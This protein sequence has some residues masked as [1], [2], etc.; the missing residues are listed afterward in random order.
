MEKNDKKLNIK[1]ER[2]EK[3]EKNELNINETIEKIFNIA[4]RKESLFKCL[5]ILNLMIEKIGTLKSEEKIQKYILLFNKIF[6]FKNKNTPISILNEYKNLYFLSLTKI[7][8]LEKKSKIFS[9]L[10][11]YSLVFEKESELYKDDSF[12][13]TK[14]IK[15]I[16][17]IFFFFL[18]MM[19]K[20]KKY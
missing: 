6:T 5:K 2:E 11:I 17:D 18:L 10:E 16:N 15:K 4:K 7:T 19:K 8:S 13:F 1:R 12:I 3:V 20:K 9:I 14:H